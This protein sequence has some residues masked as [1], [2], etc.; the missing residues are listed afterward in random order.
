MEYY[1]IGE[2]CS[3]TKGSTGNMKT[4]PGSFPLVTTGADR[5][6]SSEYEFDDEA[7]CIPLVSS[8]GHGHKSLNYIHYQSGKFALGTI[9]AAVIPKDKSVLSAEFLQRYLFFFKEK[10]VVSLMKGAANV[11]LA[12]RDIAKIQVPVPPISKQKEFIELFN[13]AED[14]KL[15]LLH[16]NQ[17]Q[18][19]YLTK[20]HQ[21]L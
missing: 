14:G 12:V 1:S 17:N 4:V 16:E 15:S 3:I 11:S 7:V 8:T 19:S 10:L 9:L 2:L 6:S 13:K 20:L 21:A 18:S 5:K